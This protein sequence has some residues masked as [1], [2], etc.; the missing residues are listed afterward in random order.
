M[1]ALLCIVGFFGFIGCVIWFLSGKFQVASVICG[2]LCIIMLVVSFFT[3]QAKLVLRKLWIS[4]VGA[5]WLVIDNSGGETLRHWVLED[6]LVKGCQYTDGW[7]FLD[8]NSNPCYVSGDSYVMEVRQ[9]VEEFLK[10]Y[11]QK[12]NIP[13]EQQALH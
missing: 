6:S 2:V 7:E 13:L 4:G 10:D 3:P 9:P 1:F 5:N 8:E 12:Y 11:R